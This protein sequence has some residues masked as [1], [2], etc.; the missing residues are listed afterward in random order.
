MHNCATPLNGKRGA[1]ASGNGGQRAGEEAG[2]PPP[3]RRAFPR[4]P[5]R[6]CAPRLSGSRAGRLAAALPGI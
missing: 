5:P 2:R 4:G 6:R 1:G 3:P